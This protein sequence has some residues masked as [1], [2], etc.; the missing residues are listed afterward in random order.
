MSNDEWISQS[1][2]KDKI[3]FADEWLSLRQTSGGYTYTHE[4]KGNGAGV[5]VLA[6][7]ISPMRVVGRYEECPP[8]RDGLALC[9]L[10]GQ[11]DQE[12]ESPVEAAV[13]EL[14]EEAG[15]TVNIDEMNSFGTVKSGKQTDTDMHLF[16]VYI[17]KDS[18]IG[19]ALGDGTRGEANAFCQ[20]ITPDQAIQSKDPILATMMARL[21]TFRESLQDASTK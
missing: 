21:M 11:M 3:L 14:E 6:Y 13:R 1:A 15:I 16:Y 2:D 4:E 18:N 10:T 17:K 8:H 19:P 9:S 5:A 12:G 7:K 20:W